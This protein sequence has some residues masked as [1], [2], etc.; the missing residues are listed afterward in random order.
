MWRRGGLE[1]VVMG[2]NWL[3]AGLVSLSFSGCYYW[4]VWFSIA[5][6]FVGFVSR[7]N[8][9][10]RL[11]F[12]SHLVGLWVLLC[13]GS[14][15]LQ[16]WWVWWVWVW[17]VVGFVTDGVVVVGGLP[18]LWGWVSLWVGYC[19]SGFL[20]W[21][22]LMGVVEGYCGGGRW[23]SLWV[24]GASLF[25]AISLS[26]YFRGFWVCSWWWWWWQVI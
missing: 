22:R 19:G 16:Q 10:S 8:S 6:G 9:G 7:Y 18:W 14:G 23:V 26:F 11:G 20:L 2:L 25:L 17:G 21:V 15:W 4:F 3:V 1:L 13:G 5:G 12:A 24:C